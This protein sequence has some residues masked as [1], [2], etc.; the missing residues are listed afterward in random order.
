LAGKISDQ[1]VRRMEKN[2]PQEGYR[3]EWDS[4]IRGFGVR[5]SSGGVT[6]FMLFYRIF[7]RQRNYTIG[8]CSEMS[9]AAARKKAVELRAQILNGQDPAEE[10]QELSN[11][12]T[13]AELLDQWLQSDELAKKRPQT[14][15]DYRRMAEKI[16]SPRLGKRRLKAITRRDISAL[17]G[18]LRDTPY[19]AN[20]VLAL[21]SAIF[22]FAIEQEW[23]TENPAR[24]V[25][26]YEEQ[27]RDRYLNK[28][29]PGEIA[30]FTA[31]LD[32]HHDQTAA[33]ALRLLLLTGS[34]L[35]EVLKAT[36]DQ[37]D[38]TRG[39]WTK[40]SHHTKQKKTEHVPLSAPALDLLECMKPSRAAGPLFPGADGKTAR[41]SIKRPWLQAL[42]AAG[43]V[44]VI[45]VEGKRKGPDGKPRMLKQYKPTVRIHDLRHT[46]ASHLA[47]SGVSLQIIGKLI[48]HTQA[49]TTMRYAHL[50]DE[51]LRAATEQ[52]G[53][54]IKFPER[55]RA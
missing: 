44:D 54:L 22:S 14:L 33:N 48:G 51:S 12:P 4:E 7:G 5:V 50:Q 15:R 20:R 46:F 49:A 41:V 10:K 13:F 16:L 53:K 21:L 32:N 35:G 6:S 37:F 9:A 55:K 18:E 38:L 24:G 17:H 25:E 2:L 27:K 52:F 45:E 43:L 11:Q 23:M 28:D 40:P 29:D 26:R 8:R 42:K 3:V 1:T 39:V 34:R 31:A 30:R 36:W 47:S 19:Q